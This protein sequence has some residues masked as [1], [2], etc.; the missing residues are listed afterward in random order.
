MTKAATIYHCPVEVTAEVIGGKWTTV[1]L[2]QLKESPRRYSELRR[3]VPDIT[4]KMLVQRLRELEAAAIV[5]RTVV[6]DTPPHVSY[7][8]TA[9]GRT[10]EPIL[11]AMFDWGLLRARTH[12]LTLVPTQP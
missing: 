4:E 10:L 2:A 11:Q 8:L 7:D 9:E 6:T 12:E 3:L 1:I 5:R